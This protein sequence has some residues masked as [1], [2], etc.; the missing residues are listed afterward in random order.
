MTDAALK[1]HFLPTKFIRW[2]R[3]GDAIVMQ[4]WYEDP[5]GPPD[6]ETLRR[7][8]EW[9][10]GEFRETITPIIAEEEV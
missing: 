1:A 9:V 3:R 5:R 7:M 4:Q 10:A 6:I 2:I 8:G